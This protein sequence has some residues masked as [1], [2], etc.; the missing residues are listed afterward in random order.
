[1]AF[2][3]TF[4]LV[5]FA[6]IPVLLMALETVFRET[7]SSSAISCNVTRPAMIPSFFWRHKEPLP[8]Y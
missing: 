7:P 3:K 1:M 8:L 2:C 5:S 6:R 4:S